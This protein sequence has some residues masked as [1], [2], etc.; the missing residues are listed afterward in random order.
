V[1]WN[2]VSTKPVA[3]LVLI[4]MIAGR[5]LFVLS[6]FSAGMKKWFLSALL[7]FSIINGFGQKPV[8]K[9]KIGETIE[10]PSK[11]D[12]IMGYK[13]RIL[14]ITTKTIFFDR[15]SNFDFVKKSGF[16]DVLYPKSAIVVNDDLFIGMRGG[17]YKINLNTKKKKSG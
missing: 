6:K 2:V 13:D 8:Q 10:L 17:V 15:T 1:I 14:I 11:S 4:P 9:R 12:I 7:L 16:W 3:I 5:E